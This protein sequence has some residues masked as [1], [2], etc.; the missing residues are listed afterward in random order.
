MSS[1]GS[2]TSRQ[3]S[4]AGPPS[5]GDGEDSEPVV[6]ALNSV[7]EFTCSVGLSTA[8]AQQDDSVTR[9]KASR[10]H[11]IAESLVLSDQKAAFGLSQC[12]HLH[13][14]NPGRFVAY[15][16]DI[17][18]EIS[19]CCHRAWPQILIDQYSSH[20]LTSGLLERL[21]DAFARIVQA[22]EHIVTANVRPG[23]QDFVD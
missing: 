4:G 11:E 7:N 9:R 14:V 17:V 18:T 12:E 21:F 23:F 19:E 20:Y 13:I 8:S 1:W 22:G 6:S 15:P 5:L 3:L 10:K 16:N 2:E